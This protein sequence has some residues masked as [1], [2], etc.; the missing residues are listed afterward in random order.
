MEVMKDAC[1]NLVGIS[2]VKEELRKTKG[3]WE[4]NSEMNNEEIGCRNVMSSNRA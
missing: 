4:Y 3:R 1:L 2:E